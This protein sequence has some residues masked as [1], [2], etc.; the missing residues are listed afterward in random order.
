MANCDLSDTTRNKIKL[1]FN[2]LA[3]SDMI[4]S[5]LELSSDIQ[6]HSLA[7]VNPVYSKPWQI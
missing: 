7:F 2:I 3:F 6:A 4:K 5:I 1:V